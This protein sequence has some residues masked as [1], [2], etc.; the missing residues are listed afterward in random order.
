[1]TE[2]TPFFSLIVVLTEKNSYLLPFT[3]DSIARELSEVVREVIIV[4]G[5]GGRAVLAHLPVEG[6]KVLKCPGSCVPELLNLALE[7]AS[8][9]YVHFLF[10]GEF[11]AFDHALIFMKKMIKGYDFPDLIYTPRR[12]RHHFG[13]PTVDMFPVT[14]KILKLGKVP[15]SLQS[16]FFR[17]EALLMLG[18]FSNKYAM[19]WGYDILCRFFLAPTLRKTF[20]RRVLTDYEYRRVRPEWIVK[21]SL[22]T[23]RISFKYFGPSLQFFQ[24]LMQNCLRLLSFSWK[25]VR[26]SFWKRHV[27][28]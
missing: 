6:V 12:V 13:Q 22:E 18:G 16:Y 9:K 2:T 10:P 8:G 5:T 24:W 25:M 17:R 27:T 20:V 14:I 19:A 26:A 7:E 4:D 3:L 1:M 15:S 21:E 28:T 11:Y 23:A